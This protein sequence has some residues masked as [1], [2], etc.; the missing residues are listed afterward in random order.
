MPGPVAGP[1]VSASMTAATPYLAAASFGV[2]ALGA[3]Q[4]GK[5]ANQ[6]AKTQAEMYARQAERERQ[7]GELNAARKR[8]EGKRVAGTQRAILGAG[9]GDMS[10]GSALLAQSEL[11]EEAELN[12]RLLESNA[13]A[14]VSSLQAQGV[15]ERAR[16]KAAQTAGYIR[17][18]SALLKGAAQFG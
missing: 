7:M 14:K 6:Q 5:A 3:I 16:G 8:K 4:Q 18:G 12:A 1:A 10:E 13:E 9:G 11:A 17:A 15:L 2:S